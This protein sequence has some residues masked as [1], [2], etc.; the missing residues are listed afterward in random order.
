M[1]PHP[2]VALVEMARAIADDPD[3]REGQL[4]HTLRSVANVLETQHRLTERVHRLGW[5][6]AT[7]VVL[8]VL[9]AA[10]QIGRMFRWWV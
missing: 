4:R 9:M 10:Y 8:F 6:F 3:Q 5:Q 1:K 7:L 2:V